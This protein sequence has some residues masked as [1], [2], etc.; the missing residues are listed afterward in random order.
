MTAYTSSGFFS[1]F[2]PSEYR[3]L[4]SVIETRIFIFDL[5]QE[6]FKVLQVFTGYLFLFDAQMIPSKNV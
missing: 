2:F 4:L 1:F 3:L 5:L 6:L